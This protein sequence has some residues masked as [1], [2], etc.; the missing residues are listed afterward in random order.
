MRFWAENLKRNLKA[1]SLV[2]VLLFATFEVLTRP[3]MGTSNPTSSSSPIQFATFEVPPILVIKILEAE[4][5]ATPA[6]GA[7]LGNR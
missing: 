7:T 1:V 5:E 4:H 2:F 6:H 3:A